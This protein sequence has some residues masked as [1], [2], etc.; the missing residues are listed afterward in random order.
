MFN[1]YEQQEEAEDDPYGTVDINPGAP[2]QQE[3]Q[4]VVL[5][6][7]SIQQLTV[8]RQMLIEGTAATPVNTKN[9]I[10]SSLDLAHKQGQIIVLDILLASKNVLSG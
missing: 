7:A 3:L 9:L 4:K 1:E 6:E 8:L 5:T 2:F 10:E